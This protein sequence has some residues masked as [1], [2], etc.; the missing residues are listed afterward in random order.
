MLY[1]DKSKRMRG[2]FKTTDYCTDTTRMHRPSKD[3]SDT[4][5]E[6][7]EMKDIPYQTDEKRVVKVTTVSSRVAERQDSQTSMQT[8]KSLEESIVSPPSWY[9]K[10]QFNKKR[11]FHRRSTRTNLSQTSDQDPTI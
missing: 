2:T 8:I 5:V 4:D 9:M 10:P 11:S 1:R 6:I 7:V 3:L